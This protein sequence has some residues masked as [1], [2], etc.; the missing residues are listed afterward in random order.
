MMAWDNSSQ[1]DNHET[2]DHIQQ[3]NQKH[4]AQMQM[5]WMLGAENE[6][7]RVCKKKT[8][9]LNFDGR[10]NTPDNDAVGSVWLLP[11]EGTPAFY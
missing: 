9:N 2:N 8:R 11:D 7:A 6:L 5:G 4:D 3:Q 1:R 10:T